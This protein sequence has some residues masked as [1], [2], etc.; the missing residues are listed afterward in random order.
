MNNDNFIS[1]C[2]DSA[3]FAQQSN[4]YFPASNAVS[5]I[6][7][8]KTEKK[9]TKINFPYNYC[10]KQKVILHNFNIFFL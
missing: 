1:Q 5:F 3:S 9:W 2:I 7:E 6:F 8:Y 4:Y 10:L